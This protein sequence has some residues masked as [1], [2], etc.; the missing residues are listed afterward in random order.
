VP[1]IFDVFPFFNELDV[2]EIRLQELAPIVEKFVIL[3]C[4]ET[5]GGDRK[6]LYLGDNWERFKPFH[7]QIVH[8]VTDRINPPQRHRL[9]KNEPGARVDEIR[10]IGRMREANQREDILPFLM[11]QNPAP[12][13]II[14]FGDC[15]EIPRA[16]AISTNLEK[17]SNQ[18]YRLKQRTYYYNVNCQIDYG[19]DVCS[20]ARV[21][22]YGQL[23]TQG[24][25]YKFR[26]AGNKDAN[27]PAIEEGGWHFSYFGGD[28]AK[29]HEKVAAL[30]PFLAEY[31]L[32]G[33]QQLVQDIAGRK[34]LHRRPVAFSELPQVFEARP[35]DDYLL[36]QYFLEHYD[37]FRHFTR[38]YFVNKYR[39]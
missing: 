22:T 8:C 32:F 19:R 26:M 18:M 29:I 14:S 15:D 28:I 23:L 39:G 12:M 24:S 1:K 34:D 33:D 5:F 27:F 6:P 2:L 11:A 10:T 30:S 36:P 20:R 31:K 37:R 9:D 13:D 16:T 25:M 38:D 35:T 3:E 4:R 7:N 17:I 21:G